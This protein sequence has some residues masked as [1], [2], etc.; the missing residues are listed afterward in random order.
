M[1]ALALIINTSAALALTCAR[2]TGVKALTVFF[3]ALGLFAVASF[4]VSCVFGPTFSLSSDA[5]DFLLILRNVIALAAS[6]LLST[7]SSA[8]EALAV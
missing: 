6:T 8:L 7:S 4:P 1:L 2:E 3:L 5:F